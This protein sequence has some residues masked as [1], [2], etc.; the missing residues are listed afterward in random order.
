[1]NMRSSFELHFGT[2]KGS[3]YI[4]ER[5]TPIQFWPGLIWCGFGMRAGACAWG[6]VCLGGG[7]I[8]SGFR[9]HVGCAGGGRVCGKCIKIK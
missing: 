3:S 1:M 2:P 5:I 9:M 8:W 6:G 4:I 7:V